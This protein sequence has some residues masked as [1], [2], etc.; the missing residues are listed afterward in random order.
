[1][2]RTYA[3]FGIRVKS[4]SRTFGRQRDEASATTLVAM[5]P[6]KPVAL[7]MA[8]PAPLPELATATPELFRALGHPLRL[9]LLMHV[10]ARGPICTCHLEE[11]LPYSQ[12]LISKHLGILRRAGLLTS[13]REGKW[14]YYSLDLDA[15]GAAGGVVEVLVGAARAP[16]LTERCEQPDA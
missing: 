1:M 16:H 7:P 2:A 3:D 14:V 10:A 11:S 5:P 13:R 15:L 9:E 6:A 4:R 8:A 12:P